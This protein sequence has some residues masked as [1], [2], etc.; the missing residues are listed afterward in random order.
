MVLLLTL[1]VKGR[2]NPYLKLCPSEIMKK[3]NKGYEPQKFPFLNSI[4]NVT[5]HS[6]TN[7]A[8]NSIDDLVRSDDQFLD[9]LEVMHYLSF[10]LL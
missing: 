8:D 3:N 7:I 6:V 5:Y 10:S 2:I 4:M 9:Q 1:H